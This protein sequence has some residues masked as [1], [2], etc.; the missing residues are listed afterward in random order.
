MRP[1]AELHQHLQPGNGHRSLKV[2]HSLQLTV[3][4]K[5]RKIRAH[6]HGS[7][8]LAVRVTLC[9][10]LGFCVDHRGDQAYACAT[11]QLATLLYAVKDPASANKTHI[12]SAQ[13]NWV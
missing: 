11:E 3:A 9:K 5:P 7:T 12:L 4:Q 6:G 8:V 10:S 2:R 13:H 1:H